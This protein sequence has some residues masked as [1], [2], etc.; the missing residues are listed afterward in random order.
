MTIGVESGTFAAMKTDR[1]P[2][3][4][5]KLTIRHSQ[6]RGVFQVLNGRSYVSGANGDTPEIAAQQLANQYE[7]EEGTQATVYGYRYPTFLSI[8]AAE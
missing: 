1:I 2:L 3:P 4:K 7:V 5:M 8:P 6:M